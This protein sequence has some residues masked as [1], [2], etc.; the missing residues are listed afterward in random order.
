MND[1]DN[2]SHIQAQMHLLQTITRLHHL[3]KPALITDS[4]EILISYRNKHCNRFADKGYQGLLMS[5]ACYW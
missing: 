2:L 1:S 5:I 4:T 3:V